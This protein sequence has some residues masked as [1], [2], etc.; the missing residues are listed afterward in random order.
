MVELFLA[1]LLLL[2]TSNN[3]VADDMLQDSERIIREPFAIGP[4][5]KTENDNLVA[6]YDESADLLTI[7]GTGNMADYIV[8]NGHPDER[9]WI[10][11]IERVE[12]IVLEEGVTS[13]GNFAFYGCSQLVKTV[14]SRT[15]ETIGE[16]AYK[17][18][19]LITLDFDKG[20]SLKKIKTGAFK[21]TK[22]YDLRLPDTL[23]EIGIDAF[24][25]CESLTCVN[26]GNGVKKVGNG[27]FAY[28]RELNK[29]VF[30]GTSAPDCYPN[31]FTESGIEIVDVVLNYHAENFCGRTVNLVDTS[32]LTCKS[33]TDEI[34]ERLED[35]EDQANENTLLAEAAKELAKELGI[36]GDVGLG[37]LIVLAIVWIVKAAIE[38][39]DK[40][41]ER[42]EK[43]REREEETKRQV[44]QQEHEER[45]EKE[46]N[47]KLAETQ[48]KA[49]DTDVVVEDS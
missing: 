33:K 26:L 29:F 31:A 41:K 6:W 22:I 36:P 35:V 43:K 30:E 32:Q 48:K 25:T 46:R 12:T 40:K 38:E 3:A 2:L 37:G 4:C 18:T 5:G 15:V 10:D 19:T 21:G 47:A 13:I 24:R 20:S 34:T 42:E 7:K 1:L 28:C 9:P 27:A 11:Y 45:M 8:S 23:T 17:K 14:I 49:A 44:L 16:A 39:R